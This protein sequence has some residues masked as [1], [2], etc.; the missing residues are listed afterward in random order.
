KAECPSA[1][2][3]AKLKYEFAQHYYRRHRRRL[4][5]YLFGYIGPL[6]GVGR[7][8]APLANALLRQPLV[9]GAAERWL[10]LAQERPLPAFARQ[11]FSAW[12]AQRKS[13][14]YRA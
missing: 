3:L 5:D 10:G 6:A 9:R 14:E 11:P 1:V 4:R 7:W 13:V 12:L 2:D 8:F